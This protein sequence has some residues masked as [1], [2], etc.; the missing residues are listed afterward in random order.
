[1]TTLIPPHCSAA[2]AERDRITQCE[3]YQLDHNCSQEGNI[4]NSFTLKKISKLKPLSCVVKTHGN[5]KL[6]CSS[7]IH[8]K[9]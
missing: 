6:S 1:M 7:I 8:I 4:N 9:F 5:N 3:S 2:Y